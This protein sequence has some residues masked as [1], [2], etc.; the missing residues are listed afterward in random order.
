M[1]ENHHN[2]KTCKENAIGEKCQKTGGSISGRFCRSKVSM[3]W[4]DVGPWCLK[5]GMEVISVLDGCPDFDTKA[6]KDWEGYA[7]FSMNAGNWIC[8]LIA[9]SIRYKLFSCLLFFLC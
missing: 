5:Y 8:E 3:D 1:A 7:D 2:C 4:N 6:D 9:D